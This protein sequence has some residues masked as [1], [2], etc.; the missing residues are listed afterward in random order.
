MVRQE[1]LDYIKDVQNEAEKLKNVNVSGKEIK[2]NINDRKEKLRQQLQ[3]KPIVSS[4][5]MVADYLFTEGY[6]SSFEDALIVA[7]CISEE[8]YN[9]IVESKD[10]VQQ[11]AL[12]L[13]GRLADAP[14]FS[15]GRRSR[16]RKIH[17]TLRRIAIK[18]GKQQMKKKQ[19]R[20]S[21]NTE[22]R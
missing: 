22:M 11:I 7:D 16:R 2:K 18:R 10:L 13:A 6:A 14:H 19:R 15:G 9:E 4:Y 12:T 20:V 8:W 21:D 5:E 3:Q 1:V 17:D